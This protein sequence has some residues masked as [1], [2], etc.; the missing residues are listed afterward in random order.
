MPCTALGG[1]ATALRRSLA[2]AALAGAL[3]WGS[4]ARAAETQSLAEAGISPDLAWAA[5]QLIP[6]PTW[7]LYADDTRFG[8]RWQLTPLL[9][10]FGRNRRL[11]PWRSLLAE[12]LAR[13]AGALEP[14]LDPEHVPPLSAVLVSH[15]HF[16][17]LSLGSLE[18]IEEKTPVLFV[19]RG[20]LP[21]VPDFAFDTIELSTWQRWEHDGLRI[22]AVPVKHGGGRYGVDIALGWGGFTGYVVEYHGITVYFGGDTA[23]DRKVFTETRARFPAI[24][25]AL[26]PIAPIGPRDFMHSRHVDPAEALDARRRALGPDRPR[27]FAGHRARSTRA[28]C[29]LRDKPRR[30]RPRGDAD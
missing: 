28:R 1:P 2:G 12:P 19:P 14:G 13:H 22:T 3:A 15:T 16:D 8:L 4:P 23:Y 9:Y 7:H 10:S 20:A 27:P 18:M 25:L 26:M 11:S 29:R 17:H 6:S 24:D 21:Y 30:G 5:S